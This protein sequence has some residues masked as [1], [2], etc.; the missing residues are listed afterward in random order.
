MA[1]VACWE[2]ED[3]GKT[4]C[5]FGSYIKT[6]PQK[7]HI[8]GEHKPQKHILFGEFNVMRAVTGSF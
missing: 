8:I 2:V 1:D 3:N 7:Q 6:N 5:A 4:K